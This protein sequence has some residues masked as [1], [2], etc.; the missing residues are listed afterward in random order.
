MKKLMSFSRA[1]RAITVPF[2]S[3]SSS[4]NAVEVPFAVVVVVVAVCVESAIQ[5]GLFL[6]LLQLVIG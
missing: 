1:L 3:S 2:S 4:P 6:S 5:T